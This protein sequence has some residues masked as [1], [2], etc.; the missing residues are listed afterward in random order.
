MNS[1]TL[2]TTS[3]TAS[4]IRSTVEMGPGATG[5]RRTLSPRMI[6]KATGS[7]RALA[8]L[9]PPKFLGCSGFWLLVTKSLPPLAMPKDRRETGIR[10]T[11]PVWMGVPMMVF[12]ST[13]VRIFSIAVLIRSFNGCCCS[14][15]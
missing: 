7:S 13:M 1:V 11:S 3:G 12:A 9:P 5:S 8:P 4:T 2:S 15:V 10:V 14:I 6:R